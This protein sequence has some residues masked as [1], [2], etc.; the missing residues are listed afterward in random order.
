MYPI[1]VAEVGWCC[2]VTDFNGLVVSVQRIV[3]G[4][5]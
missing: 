4:K 1:C 5:L 2:S 3:G